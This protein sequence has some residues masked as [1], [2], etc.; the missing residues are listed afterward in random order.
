MKKSVEKESTLCLPLPPP[1]VFLIPFGLGVGIGLISGVP[2]LPLPNWVAYTFGGVAIA[3]GLAVISWSFYILREKGESPDYRDATRSLITSGPFRV[4]RNPFYLA[5]A[6]IGCG[7]A[8]ALESIIALVVLPFACLALQVFVVSREER[9]LSALFGEQ[10]S[11]Y[12]QQ[13]RRWI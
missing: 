10:Y 4:S 3:L 2:E 12:R 8:L 5:F 13:T 11:S 9:H 1:V 6:F 7:I